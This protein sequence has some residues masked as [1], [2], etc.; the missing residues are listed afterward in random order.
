MV[1]LSLQSML[2]FASS[3]RIR[4][5]SDGPSEALCPGGGKKS[6]LLARSRGIVV[7]DNVILVCN[8]RGENSLGFLT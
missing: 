4:A 8:N 7:Q 1:G 5:A 3:A 6:R 2:T